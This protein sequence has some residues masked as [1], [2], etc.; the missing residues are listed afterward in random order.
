MTS[1]PRPTPTATTATTALAKMDHTPVNP[2][3]SVP[4]A[5]ASSTSS[6][7]LPVS[8]QHAYRCPC[9]PDQ[10]MPLRSTTDTTTILMTST[11]TWWR[12]L[13]GFSP[14]ATS[15]G[16]VTCT[17][18]SRCLMICRSLSRRI[19][20]TSSKTDK[21]VGF[22]SAKKAKGNKFNWGKK[23]LLHH[24]GSRPFSYR[25]EA[26]RKIDNFADVYIRPGDELTNSLHVSNYGGERSV[27]ASGVRLLTSFGHADRVC[28]SH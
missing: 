11:R 2:V 7:A 23:T 19:A 28:G 10:M 14:N 9:T 3:D 20:R 6:V 22:G 18:I 26:S 8:A 1:T 21:I 13:I 27:G 17:S 4:Y 15:S 24:S 5:P 25:M 16:N 12:T